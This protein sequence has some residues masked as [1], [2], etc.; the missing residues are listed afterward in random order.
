MPAGT[1]D[2]INLFHSKLFYY[3]LLYIVDFVVI[4][5][6]SFTGPATYGF[7]TLPGEGVGI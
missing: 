1:T 3:A 6:L 4:R 7:E 5:L 2:V